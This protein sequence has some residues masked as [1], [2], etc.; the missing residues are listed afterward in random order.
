[1]AGPP[2]LWS[3]SS[4]RSGQ[5]PNGTWATSVVC[6]EAQFRGRQ[7][8]PG[9]VGG[10]VGEAGWTVD[11][12]FTSCLTS[13]H[14]QIPAWAGHQPL[15]SRK[16]KVV[17]LLGVRPRIRFH[18]AGDQASC[19]PPGLHTKPLLLESVSWPIRSTPHLSFGTGA[20]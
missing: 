8:E 7:S 18:S 6:E 4:H 19:S 12:D 1:M 5:I 15:A 16:S 10:G 13:L 2:A 11:P 14:S 20:N 9:N 17:S 3:P